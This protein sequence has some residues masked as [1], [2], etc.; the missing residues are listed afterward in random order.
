M[1]LSTNWLSHFPHKKAD[2]GSSPCGPTNI[3]SV[4]LRRIAVKS[5]S[6]AG[7]EPNTIMVAVYR[8][9]TKPPWLLG[10]GR[11]HISGQLLVESNNTAQYRNRLLIC[12]TVIGSMGVRV[13]PGSPFYS[14]VEADYVVYVKSKHKTI[15]FEWVGNW[16]ILRFTTEVW[17]SG[18][19]R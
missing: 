19:W 9:L 2:R 8:I 6:R 5:S 1:G 11:K 15:A 7:I 13:S 12:S 3:N 4:L 18:L 17:P 10:M 16:K 14:V